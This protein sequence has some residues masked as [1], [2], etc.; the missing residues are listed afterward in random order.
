MS[1]F[2]V[3]DFTTIK[4]NNYSLKEI[5]TMDQKKIRTGPGKAQVKCCILL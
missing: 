1:L 5:N 4:T 3:F 2:I